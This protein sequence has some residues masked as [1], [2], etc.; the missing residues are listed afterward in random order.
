MFIGLF[1]PDT[2]TQLYFPISLT[3]TFVMTDWVLHTE[4]IFIL[5]VSMLWIRIILFGF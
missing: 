1:S 3:G 4:A 2:G 5:T